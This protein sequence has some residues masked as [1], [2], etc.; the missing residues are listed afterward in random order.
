MDSDLT[1]KLDSAVEFLDDCDRSLDAGQIVVL[2]QFENDMV[3]LC[4]K[5]QGK[6]RQEAQSYIA[7]LQ[8]IVEKLNLLEGRMQ[9]RKMGL[10]RQLE[11]L[12][13]GHK[14][15]SAYVK[16]QKPKDEK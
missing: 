7:R 1:E 16:A 9:K 6:N 5:I 8:T 10:K 2:T 11:D 3:K 15:A 12:N 13:S 4:A 14:A